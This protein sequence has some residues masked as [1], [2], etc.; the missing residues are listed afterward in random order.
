MAPIRGQ[1]RKPGPDHSASC[2]EDRHIRAR[3]LMPVVYDELHRRATAYLP[4]SAGSHAA[5][6]GAGEAPFSWL[7]DL[8]QR[9][10]SGAG[11]L[12]Q[13]RL[14]WLSWTAG[15]CILRAYSSQ[16]G[17]SSF[18][19]RMNRAEPRMGSKHESRAK[20]G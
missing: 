10:A 9:K 8:S 6:H 14:Q 12:T 1:L 20:A 16:T 5:D 11:V 7:A 15:Y 19:N 13:H 18:M 4:L 2:M 17:L 3:P